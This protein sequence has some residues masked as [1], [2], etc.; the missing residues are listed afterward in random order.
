MPT[1]SPAD[2]ADLLSVATAIARGEEVD[3]DAANRT[4][5]DTALVNE[6]RVI[7][8]VARLGDRIPDTW[9]R[10]TIAG[11]LGRGSH[12]T[13]YRAHD[14][15]L[16]VDVALK[17]VRPDGRAGNAIVARALN[18]ARML[19]QINH[20][21]VVRVFWA[22]PLGSDVGVAMELVN[23]KT[24]REI[25][26]QQFPLEVDDILSI[27]HDVCRA[28]AAVHA[29]RMLH[30]DIKAGNVMRTADGRTVLMD[31]GV[32]QDLKVQETLPLRTAGTP[33]YLAPELFEGQARTPQADIYSAGVL[34]YHLATDAYPID[35]HDAIG[36]ER[37]HAERRPTRPIRELRPD[38]PS[39]F[40]AIVERAI[41][42][43]P[44]DRYQTAAEFADE[45][46]KAR[47]S[48]TVKPWI[49][50]TGLSVAAA[51]LLAI[52]V[53]LAWPR[54]NGSGTTAGTVASAV[55]AAAT[56]VAADSYKIDAAF[57]RLQGK[58]DVRLQPGARV[59]PGD[60][61]SLRIQSSVP[62]YAYVVNE[63]DRG[64]S[65]LLFPLSN[66]Q[67]SNP[68]P[69]GTRHEI[70]GLV[71]GEHVR[72]EVSS[73]GGREHFLIFVTPEKP[74]PAFE[75]IFANLPRPSVGARTLAQRMPTEVVGALRG[76]GSLAKSPAAASTT[77]LADEFAVPLPEREE[78]A[79]GVWI[80]QLT[81]DNPGR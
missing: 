50:K 11:E 49:L 56:T 78:T 38:L 6:L 81:L 30:G 44:G 32:G 53:Y 57:Y 13:V 18:E 36:V 28:L 46:E 10:L 19:A 58:T 1:F 54:D 39:S 52:S 69:A 16:G 77:R 40:V 31:F 34:L 22:E 35:A 55:P 7:D 67:L 68:L 29:Q 63:D 79:R 75:R 47:R 26:R 9:G 62:V 15:H 60:N 59:A 20:P 8:T 74:S 48:Q 23:G 5:T 21:N 72:W 70:P 66:Q 51:A 17:V 25:V 71:D 14:P 76:V 41:A 37:H 12:G 43:R 42:R 61:L 73:S 64:E 4:T 33:L 80:R 3:W 24:L 2:E 27:G 45:I 65:F